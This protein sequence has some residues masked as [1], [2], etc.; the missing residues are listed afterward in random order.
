MSIHRLSPILL[1]VLLV[2]S[3]LI[4]SAPEAAGT[5]LPDYLRLYDSSV[6]FRGIV[7]DIL[8]RTGI[9]TVDVVDPLWGAVPDT[10]LLA[11]SIR[12]KGDDHTHHIDGYRGFGLWCRLGDDLVVIANPGLFHEEVVYRIEYE[13]FLILDS[14]GTPIPSRQESGSLVPQS[15]QPPNILDRP[16]AEWFDFTARS[17]QPDPLTYDELRLQIIEHLRLRPKRSAYWP[18]PGSGDIQDLP[19][20]G[21]VS[22]PSAS[23]VKNS[24]GKP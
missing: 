21:P 22:D 17:F 20:L 23:R 12:L 11:N 15:E 9:I 16:Y 24:G 1:G 4:A 10:V 8:P 14:H 19:D 18:P 6:A 13:R 2:P 5:S 7:I 3:F